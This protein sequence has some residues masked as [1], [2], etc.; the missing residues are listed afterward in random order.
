M[1]DPGSLGLRKPTKAQAL[2]PFWFVKTI[3]D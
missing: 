1:E 2:G 3:Q